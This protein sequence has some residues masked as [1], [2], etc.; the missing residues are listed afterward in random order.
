MVV[1]QKTYYCGLATRFCIPGRSPTTSM[2]PLLI[3]R[4]YD[5]VHTGRI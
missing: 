1:K 2:H 4:V 5:E 3:G